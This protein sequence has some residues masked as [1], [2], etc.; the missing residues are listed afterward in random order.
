MDTDLQERLRKELLEF[1]DHHSTDYAEGTLRIPTAVYTDPDYLRVEFERVTRRYPVI[2]AH[3]GELGGEPGCFLRV[4]VAGLDLLVVRQDD[5][6]VKALAN[7]CRHRGTQLESV[8]CGLR[9]TFSCPYHRWSYDRA[10]A[11]RS[12]PF[13]DGF[14]R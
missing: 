10:G 11:L 3:R 2:V 6:T 13:D 4:D 5:G 1:L 9:R 8:E 12:M 7:V 14:H